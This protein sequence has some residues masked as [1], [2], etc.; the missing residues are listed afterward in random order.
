MYEDIY[1]AKAAADHLSGF[2][3]GNRYLIGARQGAGGVA[4]RAVR[5]TPDRRAVLFHSTTRTKAKDK[6][7]LRRKEAELSALQKQQGVVPP[8]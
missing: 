6:S 1:D 3:V 5:A 2:N 4:G 7:E 8:T